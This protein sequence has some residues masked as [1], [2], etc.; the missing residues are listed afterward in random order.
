MR[1]SRA[2]KP[3]DLGRGALDRSG[4]FAVVEV[5]DGGFDAVG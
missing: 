3:S 4:G 5:C 1:L 2:M